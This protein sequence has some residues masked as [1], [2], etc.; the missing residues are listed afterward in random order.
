MIAGNVGAIS[1][2]Q[3]KFLGNIS[4]SG[5]HLLA[6]INNILDISKI[7]A[8]KMELSCETFA[9]VETINEVKQLISPLVEKKGLKTEFSLDEKLVNIYADKIRFKQI[10]F[11]LAS[12]AIKFTPAGGMITISSQICGEMAQFTVRDTGIGIKAEDQHKLFKPFTQLD[13]A[14]NRM[15]EGT[16][17]GLSLV[18]SFVELHKG[19]IW[20]ESEVGKGTAFTFEIP[21]VACLSKGGAAEAIASEEKRIEDAKTISEHSKA[22]I[23]DTVDVPSQ[24]VHIPQII[25]PE[26]SSSDEPL[27]LVVEDDDASRE[28]LEVTLTQEGYRVA[29][30]S[31]G[32]E[33]LELANTMKPFAITLDIMMPGMSGWDVLKH[34]KLEIQTHNIPVIIT[35]MLDEKDLGVVWGAVEHFIKPIQKDKLLSTLEKI[36]GKE[37]KSSL[38]VL[39]ADDEKTAVELVAA[40]LN[41]KELNVL[42]ACGGQEAIDIAFK[43]L[44]DVIILDLMMP[45]ISGYDVIKTL[46]SRPDTVDIPIIIC[47]AKD[48]D[49]YDINELSRNVSSIMHK[50]M[51]SREDM[52]ECIKQLQ[53]ANLKEI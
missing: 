34:L 4:M 47:T 26:N 41:E 30:V 38:S 7:E 50:G 48:L 8:G 16:G 28:L 20:F 24:K 11:N 2:K 45:E 10:I 52:L 29:S 9:V 46:K 14:T 49:P 19:K 42:K 18:K 3:K 33:A 27:I 1:E 35:T 25:E 6:L 23:K 5:K 39:V 36:K 40:M 51:F 31:S 32:K 12:N 21:L 13:S 37:A 53:K 22:T 43:E 44:P 17:L 15:Y